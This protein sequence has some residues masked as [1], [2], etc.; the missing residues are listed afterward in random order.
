ML[1]RQMRAGHESGKHSRFV[2][3]RIQEILFLWL[4]DAQHETHIH[5]LRIAADIVGSAI[6]CTKAHG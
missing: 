4:G 6:V 5:A 2:S 3:A 1:F